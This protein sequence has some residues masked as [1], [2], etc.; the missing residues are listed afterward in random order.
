MLQSLP[1]AVGGADD[2]WN[3]FLVRGGADDENV[4]LIDD[5]E[6]NNL[7]HWGT[8][9][10]SSGTVS[11][12]HLDFVRDLDFYAGGFPCRFPPRLSS[13][14]DLKFREGSK[15]DRKWQFDLNMAGTGIF[16][17]GPIVREKSSY[18]LNARVSYLGLLEPLL[19]LGGV[20]H[21]QNGQIKLVFDLTSKDKLICNILAGNETVTFESGEKRE[22]ASSGRLVIGGVQWRKHITG[23]MNKLLL[24]GI[25][26]KTKA[27]ECLVDTLHIFDYRSLHRRLQLKDDLTL[28]FRDNDLL[29]VGAV[30]ERTHR[31]SRYV[32]NAIYTWA[33]S[34]SLYEY[35]AHAPESSEA[36]VVLPIPHD[37]ITPDNT[38]GYR[39]GGYVGYTFHQGRL[40]VNVGLRDDY[41]TLLKKHGP[42]PRTGISYELGTQGTGSLSGALMYQFPTYLDAGDFSDKHA[43]YELQRNYQAVIGY[44]RQ[45][46]DVVIGGIE[47]FYKYYDREPSYTF[48]TDSA[49]VLIEVMPDNYGTKKAYGIEFHLRKKRRDHFFYELAYTFYSVRRQYTN[50]AWYNDHNN[51]RNTATMIVGSNFHKNHGVSVRCDLSEGRPY[52]PI[53]EEASADSFR[54]VYDLSV[55]PYKQRRDPRIKLSLRYNS[56]GYYRW[57]N[58]TGYVEI[59]NLLNQKDVVNEYFSAGDGLS[60]TNVVRYLSRGIFI[61]GGVTV[62]L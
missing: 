4:F 29:T 33:R 45:F 62:D 43:D 17:E 32:R 49:R 20:P 53:D 47:S 51:L 3:S 5:I 13:I 7:S 39:L 55:G 38:V 58:I 36:I 18:M 21:Y 52:T 48:D 60:E 34:D 27:F 25:Y 37:T 16:M 8:E 11:V 15:I 35:T 30:V 6:I 44:E 22:L 57:G 41:F 56:T 54:T 31:D 14:V 23:G 61:V 50:G 12:L 46:S 40:K 9:S 19:D 10:G 42:S 24:S 2:S 1:S 26:H 28:F 59:Q